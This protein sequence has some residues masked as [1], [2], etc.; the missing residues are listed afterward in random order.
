M[1]D[2]VRAAGNII[3]VA[4][5]ITRLRGLITLH[6]AWAPK[7]WTPVRAQTPALGYSQGCPW[8]PEVFKTRGR[9]C[10][11]RL[12]HESRILRSDP[13]LRKWQSTHV[14]KR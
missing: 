6:S 14:V 4:A 5:C 13:G 8:Q 11:E 2:G 9:G 1:Q 3:P 7:V 10:R 12:H